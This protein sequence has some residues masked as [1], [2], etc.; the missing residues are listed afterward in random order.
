MLKTISTAGLAP[1]AKVGDKNLEQG[2]KKIQME[3]QDKK[4]LIQKSHK[5]AKGQK[6]AKSKK[7]I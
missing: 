4:E 1:S 2:D 6:T 7:W 3:N 5:I